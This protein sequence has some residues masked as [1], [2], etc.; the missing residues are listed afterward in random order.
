MKKYILILLLFFSLVGCTN[1]APFTNRS[2]MILISK[3][4]E[5]ALGEKSYEDTLKKSEVITN[6]KE[7]K[8]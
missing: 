2:Q 1:K 3:D 6:T 8:K 5:L 7:S 4:Q